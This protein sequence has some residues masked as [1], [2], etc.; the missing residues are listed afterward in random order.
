MSGQGLFGTLS[1]EKKKRFMKIPHFP[2]ENNL[3]LCEFLMFIAVPI[4]AFFLNQLSTLISFWIR[5][6]SPNKPRFIWR[7]V[8]VKPLKYNFTHYS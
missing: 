2:I 1:T 6:K 5:E 7:T 8:L 3:A 4:A